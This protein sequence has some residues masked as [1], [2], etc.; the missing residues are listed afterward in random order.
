MFFKIKL[1]GVTVG[2]ESLYGEAFDMCRDYLCDGPEAF[3][4]SV[5][6]SDIDFEREK[7]VRE[8][9]YERRPVIDYPDPYLETLAIYRKIAVGMLDHGVMLM[10]GSAVCADGQAYFFTAP[11]G[12]GK[13]THSQLWLE[14]I[15]GSFIINGDKPL[16]KVADGGC[17]LY[18]TTW[19]GKEGVNRNTSAPLKA[20]C[21]IERGAQ[22]SVSE[23]G[24][25]DVFPL[26]L[27][28]VYIPAPR[29]EMIKTMNLIKELGSKT[30]FYKLACNMEPEAALIA[31][32]GMNR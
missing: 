22:N 15:A 26:L 9:I 19:A 25:S 14:N 32:E 12:V 17:T 29:E 18:G 4:V 10:H 13:T 23:V 31:Y 16:V 3:T 2:V 20:I 7:S 1:A 5:A 30:R 27:S 21:F 11:S 24:F 28:Q 8:A 6:Q